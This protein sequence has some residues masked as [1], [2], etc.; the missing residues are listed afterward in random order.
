MPHCT[1][2]N[3][4][5]RAIVLAALVAALVSCSNGD[6]TGSDPSSRV[7][8]RPSPSATR[9]PSGSDTRRPGEGY[10][11]FT[12]AQMNQAVQFVNDFIY[13]SNVDAKTI[14]VTTLDELKRIS[15]YMTPALRADYERELADDKKRTAW[16][17]T[18]SIGKCTTPADGRAAENL[19]AEPVRWSGVPA[20]PNELAGKIAF[21]VTLR[22]IDPGGQLVMQ[23]IHRDM[24]ITLQLT[25]DGWVLSDYG[26]NW[27]TDPVVKGG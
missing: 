8:A 21:A 7:T 2:L 14:C 17:S 26:C 4:S 11:G 15:A 3:R 9:S 16:V 6:Y 27:R 1:A 5:G 24:T 13:L 23:R 22:T 20:T 12:G 18:W 10:A 25:T 19:E